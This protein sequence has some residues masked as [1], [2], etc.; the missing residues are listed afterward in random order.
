M[1]KQTPKIHKNSHNTPVVL[2]WHEKKNLKAIRG[3]GYRFVPKGGTYPI[4]TTRLVVRETL[5][6]EKLI[7]TPAPNETI[8]LPWHVAAV[9][10]YHVKFH[11]FQTSFRFSRILKPCI[12]MLAAERQCQGVWHSF[13][14]LACDLMLQPRRNIWFCNPFLWTGACACSSNLN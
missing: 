13:S 8:F 3:N 9:P 10:S 2:C 1:S 14:F 6:C 7:P 4:E 12:S 5:V 11:Q